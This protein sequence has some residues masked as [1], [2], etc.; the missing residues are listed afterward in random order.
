MKIAIVDA[1]GPTGIHLAS[2]L[3]KNAAAV[4]VVGRGMDKL[5]RLFPDTAI[6]KRPADIL[7]A[8]ATCAR[9]MAA[10]SS[11]IASVYRAIKCSYIR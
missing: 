6:E 10:T 5:A 8:D 1:T 9:S 2:E 7:D 3:R 11:M 4:C